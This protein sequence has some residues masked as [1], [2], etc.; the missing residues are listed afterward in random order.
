[1]TR[2]L[3]R[4][5]PPIVLDTGAFAGRPVRPVIAVQGRRTVAEWDDPALEWDAPNLKITNN[6]A[7]QKLISKK[8]R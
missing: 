8:Y 1:M 4:P 7:A 3:D 2:L 5:L 6:E